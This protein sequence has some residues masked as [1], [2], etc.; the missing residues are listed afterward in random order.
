L[1]R[2]QRQKEQEQ[3]CAP[4]SQRIDK[5]LWC[6]RIAKTRALAAR[7][8]QAGHV[9]VNRR[10][11][12]RASAQVR[13]GDVLTIWRHGQVLVLQVAGFTERRLPAK[14]ARELY[15]DLSEPADEACDNASAATRAVL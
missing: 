14:L 9:R 15:A 2:K 13:V 5:W 7:M 4:D 12:A 1:S 3:A 6:T 11:L 8:V 10:K